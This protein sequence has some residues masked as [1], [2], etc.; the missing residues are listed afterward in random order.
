MPYTGTHTDARSYIY[1]HI[2]MSLERRTNERTN[3]QRQIQR[4][5]NECER[6]KEHIE[7]SRVDEQKMMDDETNCWDFI[8]IFLFL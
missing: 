8:Q 4:R 6:H 2:H 1:S 7:N 5:T 3:E